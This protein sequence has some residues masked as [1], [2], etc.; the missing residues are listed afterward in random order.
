M[1]RRFCARLDAGA[2]QQEKHALDVLGDRIP[3]SRRDVDERRPGRKPTRA[4]LDVQRGG[5][6]CKAHSH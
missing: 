2:H 5:Q 1:I 4:G 6:G 3:G